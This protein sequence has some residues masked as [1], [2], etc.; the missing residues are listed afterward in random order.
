METKT[1]KKDPRD[2]PL[3][4]PSLIALVSGLASQAMVSL[5]VFPNPITGQTTMMLH[6]AK[7]LIDTV[8]LLFEKTNGNRSD[9]ETQTIDSVL[10]ELRMVYVAAQNEWARRQSGDEATENDPSSE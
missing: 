4:A 9:E 2:I 5:G 6:Q 10:H 1:P 3:P 7:H 8:E